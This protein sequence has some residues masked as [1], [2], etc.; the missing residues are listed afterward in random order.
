LTAV[1]VF[2]SWRQS[3]GVR[4]L[5]KDGRA[6]EEFSAHDS[7]AICNFLFRF[8][9][10]E[11]NPENR[12]GVSRVDLFYPTLL[13]ADGAVLIDTPGVGSTFRHNTEAALDVLPE[14]DAALFVI[15]A[16]P[17]ITEA[18]LDFLRHVKAKTARIFYILNKM[19]YLAADERQSIAEFLRKV[20]EQNGLWTP[21][22]KIFSVS[23]RNGLEAGQR[24]DRS[25]FENSGMAEVEALLV[26]QLATE[27]SHLLQTAMT[28]NVTDSLAQG[29]AE[30]SLRIQA[31]KLPLDDLAAKS[32]LFAESLHAIEERQRITRDVLAGEQRNIRQEIERSI[33][34][35]RNEAS[36]ELARH[37]GQDQAE[38][39]IQEA[40]S[41]A[42]ERI[43]DVA[44]ATMVEEFSGRT[45]A[46]LAIYQK[47]I[48][49]DVETVRRTAADIFQ[50]PFKESSDATVFRLDHEPYWLTQETSAS[51]L[52]DPG[53]WLE[54]LFPKHLRGR[55]I[56]ARM[57]GQIKELVV[58][59]AEN[60]RWTLL[61]GVDE[62]FRQAAA[63][64][65]ARLDDAV[66]ATRG[67][68]EESLMRRRDA[69]NTIEADLERL[70][71][72]GELL[73]MLHQQIS[74][75]R[76]ADCPAP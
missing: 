40:L 25:G 6:P 57:L 34:S 33:A 15:S 24:G 13:L 56:R 29:V 20:L 12:L 38:Q 63:N 53:R 71:R 50:T 17:P 4:V 18:E 73:S 2:I 16:D 72:A 39:G 69:S 5:F 28:G 22:S 47:R 68:I 43:F 8:V 54:R 19:D 37:L 55:R 48:D 7:D 75:R 45:D 65:Q 36:S 76:I 26:R 30:V 52:P 31:L 41:G 64:L 61:R 62:A 23:A 35:L 70:N 10:E 42:I 32:K 49:A 27:K 59:N 21:A 9:A 1:P 66:S 11:G 67:V 60:L 58:R 3:P 51:L 46:V 74:G 44:R 14:C